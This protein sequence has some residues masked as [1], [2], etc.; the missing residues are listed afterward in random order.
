M[1]HTPNKLGV[2]T[3]GLAMVA[4]AGLGITAPAV[5]QAAPVQMSSHPGP[6]PGGGGNATGSAKSTHCGKS[7][8]WIKAA[9]GRLGN[10]KAAEYVAVYKG[11]AITCGEGKEVKS[12]SKTTVKSKTYYSWKGT[13]TTKKG[14]RSVAQYNTLPA[15]QCVATDYSL[16]NKNGKVVKKLRGLERCSA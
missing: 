13:T 10:L 15:R 3:V 1:F 11:K 7:R 16:L 2:A 9:S 12:S 8:E 14:K 4:T 6:P 5:A